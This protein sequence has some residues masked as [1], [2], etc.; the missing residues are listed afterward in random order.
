MNEDSSS[1]KSKRLPAVT[2]R[3]THDDLKRLEKMSSTSGKTIP[4]ILRKNT[5]SRKELEQ[6]LL[7]REQAN[8]ILVALSRIGNNLNQISKRIN[9]GLMSGW[10]QAFNGLYR[11]WLDMKQLFSVNSGIR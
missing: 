7:T 3:V 6:P 5:L 11:E 4:E 9:S 2:V 10:N 8:E 1:K